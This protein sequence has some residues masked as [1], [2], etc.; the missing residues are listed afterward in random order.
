MHS[1]HHLFA[2][3]DQYFHTSNQ[4][5]RLTH[6]G[7][8]R[9]MVGFTM[10]A[11][12]FLWP[13]YSTIIS[14]L[15]KD[16]FY[17]G[18]ACICCHVFYL[19]WY[20]TSLIFHYILYVRKRDRSIVWATIIAAVVNHGIEFSAHTALWDHGAALST[21]ASMML[22]LVFKIILSRDVPETRQIII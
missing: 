9:N 12:V 20:L 22:I 16:E 4:H 11:A 19:K 5:Y 21:L 13:S 2:Q 6:G 15:H 17:P 14:F 18:A 10:L 1:G 7:L 3:T 8:C